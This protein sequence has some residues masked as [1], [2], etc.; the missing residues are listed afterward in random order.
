MAAPPLTEAS[1]VGL[2]SVPTLALV[3]GLGAEPEL[4]GSVGLVLYEGAPVG[5]PVAAGVAAVG[6][7]VLA[8]TVV[9]NTVGGL[10]VAG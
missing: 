10:G 8:C 6:G 4:G 2:C 7:A 3:A 9:A 5:L 1:T